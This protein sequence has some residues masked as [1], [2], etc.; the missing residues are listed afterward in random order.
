MV[1]YLNEP[2]ATSRVFHDGFVLTGDLGSL[3]ADG[4]LF[5]LG[6][7]KP[8]ISVAG[9]KVAPAEVE[10]CLRLHPAVAEAQVFG[11]SAPDGG[12]RVSARIV[13]VGEPDE[14]EIRRFLATQLADFK[15]PSEFVFARSSRRGAL[16]KPGRASDDA[17]AEGR[18]H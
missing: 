8:M 12:E 9:K 18:E 5:V 11:S 3:S 17:E 1:G 4:N 7:L 6:R 15:I 16:A 2:E 10:A 13:P 14:L